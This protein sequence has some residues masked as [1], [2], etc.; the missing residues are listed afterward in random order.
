[1]KQ[2]EI[3][4][5]LESLPPCHSGH[6]AVGSVEVRR[7]VDSAESY[8]RLLVEEMLSEAENGLSAE[9][10]SDNVVKAAAWQGEVVAYKKILAAIDNG[11]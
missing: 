2:S 7:I 6:R 1:M 9:V 11:K 8:I 4:I 3:L 10:L 5:L